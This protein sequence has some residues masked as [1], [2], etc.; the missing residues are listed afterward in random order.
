MLCGSCFDDFPILDAGV[1]SESASSTIRAVCRLLGF[2]CSEDKELEFEEKTAMLG[3]V[4][5]TSKV[6]EAVHNLE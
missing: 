3:V 5:D 4:F 2:K 6:K 1:T